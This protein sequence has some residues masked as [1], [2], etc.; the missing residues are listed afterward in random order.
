MAVRSY[1]K[2]YED[3]VFI[4]APAGQVFDYVDDHSRFSSHMSQSSWMMGGGRMNTELDDGRGQTVGS[5]IRLNGK[6]FGI[7]LFLDEVV[8]HRQPPSRKIWETVGT[9]KLL[10][11]GNYR[12]GLEISSENE[13]SRLRIFID[14]ELPTG[15]S[16]RWLGYLFGG[17]YAKWCVRQMVRGVCE[18]FKT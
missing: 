7:N 16:T 18:Q 15:V 14:Y 10:V 9:P 17:I 8:T 13:G 2:H 5:H 4:R 3:S 6:V 1:N 12:M 11:I